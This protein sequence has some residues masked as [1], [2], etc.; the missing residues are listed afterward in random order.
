[1]QLHNES[2]SELT[3]LATMVAVQ[4]HKYCPNDTTA[5]ESFP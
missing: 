3:G 4:L 2:E 5:L 1:V